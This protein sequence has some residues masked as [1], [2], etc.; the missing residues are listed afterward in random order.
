MIAD[1]EAIRDQLVRQALGQQ[2]HDL[3]L[4]LGQLAAALAGSARAAGCGT[5]ARRERGV[6][7]GQAAAHGG[8]RRV[9]A[10]A[11]LIAQHDAARTGGEGRRDVRRIADDGDHRHRRA[12][13]ARRAARASCSASTPASHSATSAASRSTTSIEPSCASRLESPARS[14]GSSVRSATLIGS[15]DRGD[16][17]SCG[18][19][20]MSPWRCVLKR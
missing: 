19:R 13:A 5:S 10:G 1:A 18:L 8:E 2:L 6:H 14:S 7:H 11:D 17:E 16:R 9:D 4:A 15:R 20:V 3:A 12:R